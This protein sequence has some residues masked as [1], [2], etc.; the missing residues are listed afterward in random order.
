[1]YLQK[2]IP[3]KQLIFVGGLKV[4]DKKSRIRCMD[5]QIRNNA[6]DFVIHEMAGKRRADGPGIG[7]TQ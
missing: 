3:G 7:S 6:Y 4:I 2:V 5:P 1:M